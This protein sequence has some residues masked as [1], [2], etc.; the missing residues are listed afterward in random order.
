MIDPY[1]WFSITMI[2]IRGRRRGEGERLP[3]VG[4]GGEGLAGLG[5]DEERMR[6]GVEAAAEHVSG[7]E[8]SGLADD[9]CAIVWPQF[10]VSVMV[11]TR[12]A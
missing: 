12:A 3:G 9:P 6:E 11:R 7:G 1:S 5:D 4:D 2:A 8:Q 10:V